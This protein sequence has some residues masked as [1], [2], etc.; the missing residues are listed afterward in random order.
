[1]K[2]LKIILLLIIGYIA[3]FPTSLSAELSGQKME[4]IRIAFMNGYANAIQ[5]DLDTIKLLK[6]DRE[7]LKKFSRA[8]VDRYMERVALL[9]REDRGAMIKK[10]PVH[11]GS[12]SLLF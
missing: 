3:I 12:N 9:N 1:M 8:A 10:K 6:R 2:S 11:T 5:A 7:R 4:I